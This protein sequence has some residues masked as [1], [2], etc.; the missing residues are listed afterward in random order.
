MED[1]AGGRLGDDD[2]VE[3]FWDFGALVSRDM[4]VNVR[5]LRASKPEWE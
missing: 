3:A 1:A 5:F 4:K 2:A